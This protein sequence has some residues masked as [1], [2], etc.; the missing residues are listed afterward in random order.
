MTGGSVNLS[1]L[2]LNP[3]TLVHPDRVGLHTH[4]TQPGR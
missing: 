4:N 1:L 3:D 2:K